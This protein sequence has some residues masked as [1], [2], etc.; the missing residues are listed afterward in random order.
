[1]GGGIEERLRNASRWQSHGPLYY[2][3]GSSLQCPWSPRTPYRDRRTGL[4]W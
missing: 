3:P 1:M 4:L 2:P